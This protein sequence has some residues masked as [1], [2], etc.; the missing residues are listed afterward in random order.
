MYIVRTGSGDYL[1]GWV[2]SY[3][4]FC[5]DREDAIHISEETL[6]E[7]ILTLTRMGYA[8]TS[9]QIA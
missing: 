4:V 9:L 6:D 2:L 5:D 8:V 7:I 1:Y 3:P